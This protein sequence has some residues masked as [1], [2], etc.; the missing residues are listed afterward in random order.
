MTEQTGLRKLLVLHGPALEAGGV[1]DLLREHFQIETVAELDDALAVM[2]DSDFVAV[3]SETADFLP[4]E[5]G[6]VTQQAAVVLDTIGDG[7]CLVGANGELGWANRRVREFPPSILEP[8][9]KRCVEAYEEFAADTSRSVRV[10]RFSLILPGGEYYEIICSPVRDHQGLLRQVA[11]MVVNATTQRRQQLKLNA[12]DRAGRELVRLDYDSLSKRDAPQ[13]LQLIQERIIKYSQEVLDYQHFAVMLLDEQANRLQL[14]FAEGLG[15]EAEGYELFAGTEGNGMCGY[16]A[17]TG[18]SYVCSDVR[19]DSHYLPG[20]DNARSSLT[21]PLRFHDK[22]VGVLNAESDRVG[23]FSESDRQFAE[24]FA[25]YV[26]MAL[27]ILDL[28]VFERYSTH[29]QVSDSMAAELAGPLNDIITNAAE[30]MEDY[31]GHDDIRG[32]LNALID[33]ATQA[34]QCVQRFVQGSSTVQGSTPHVQH[35]PILDGKRVLVAD[36][37]QLLRQTVSDVLTQHG[38]QV[39]QAVDGLDAVR[40]IATNSY[41]LIISDI[42][43]PGASGYEVFSTTVAANPDT[44]VILMTAFGYDPGHSVVRANQEGLS[45]VLFK[46]F[47][48]KQLLVECRKALSPAQP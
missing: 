2:R 31:I 32:R 35:D 13:R 7:V 3:L 8:I 12:I 46:P 28:L 34:R 24:I 18:R 47:K 14:L 45:A 38:C 1:L 36:D 40:Q 25:N 6:I 17:A 4:L 27:N 19:K 26:A 16:V 30:I 20:M 43:M 37:E 15:A 33:C 5:R 42:K 22:I 10:R 11:A 39:D 9:R 21:V 41:D 44:S 29:T 23:A 48:V